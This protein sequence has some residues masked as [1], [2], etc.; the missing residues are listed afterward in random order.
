MLS[1]MSEGSSDAVAQ[2]S[3]ND[4]LWRRLIYAKNY[5]QLTQLTGVY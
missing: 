2:L 3:T 1:E 4:Y 5:Q